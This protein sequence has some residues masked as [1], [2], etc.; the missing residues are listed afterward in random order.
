MSHHYIEQQDVNIDIC[1]KVDVSHQLANGMQVSLGDL[2]GNFQKL[3]YAGVRHG[4]LQISSVDFTRLQALYIKSPLQADDLTLFN[5]LLARIQ[6]NPNAKDSL[7][8]LIGDVLADRGKNDYFTLKLLQKFKQGGLPFEILI[9]NHDAEFIDFFENG[10]PFNSSRLGGQANSANQLQ[11]LIDRNLVSRD[12][13]NSLIEECYK[14]SLKA[15][16]YSFDDA[17][18]LT[19]YSHAAIGPYNICFMANAL[20]VPWLG[21]DEQFVAM[22]I[23]A[24]NSEFAKHVQNNTVSKLINLDKVPLEAINGFQ[25]IDA[26]KFPFAHLIWNRDVASLNRPAHIN[27]VHGHDMRDKTLGNIFNLD[28][29]LGKAPGVYHT[30]VYNA[31]YSKV[32]GLK[33]A[34]VL[35]KIIEDYR[36]IAAIDNAK[37]E[38]VIK[39]IDDDTGAE[40]TFVTPAASTSSIWQP[41]KAIAG[42]ASNWWWGKASEEQ[43][44]AEPVQKIAKVE[45][46]PING[47]FKP[48]MTLYTKHGA[49]LEGPIDLTQSVIGLPN[50]QSFSDYQAKKKRLI[51]K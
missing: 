14:P 30:G 18:K 36:P 7:L 34:L 19:V 50:D 32:A 26:E 23:D 42:T 33:P 51:V 47:P 35:P 3:L 38:P 43:T 28:N 40:W 10:K 24:V 2:H 11:D 46:E 21:N 4:A 31:L 37:S 17:G 22:T 39:S 41:L 5:Q 8:R 29:Q 15:L 1:P 9:S 25:P 16:S 44:A 49:K 12:E 27:W 20:N 13:I 48:G 6:V 45:K